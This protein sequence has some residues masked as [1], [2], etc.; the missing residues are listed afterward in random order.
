MIPQPIL[1][2]PTDE[3]KRLAIMAA[4]DMGFALGP[5]PER[6]MALLNRWTKERR[7]GNQY[8][9]LGGMASGRPTIHWV[10][11]GGIGSMLKRPDCT[12]VNS[13]S[14]LRSY[15][16]KHHVPRAAPQLV[17]DLETDLDMPF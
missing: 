16:A 5:T 11:S 13:L 1:S 9:L 17:V 4:H 7:D 3:S 8:M 15:I 2:V 12:L 14:H 10:T 6:S